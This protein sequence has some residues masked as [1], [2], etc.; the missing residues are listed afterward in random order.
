M[1]V[2]E[3]DV[4]SLVV[5]LAVVVLINDDACS[6]VNG[7]TYLI[8]YLI[9]STVFTSTTL[10]PIPTVAFCCPLANDPPLTAILICFAATESRINAGEEDWK[11]PFRST[12]WEVP[13]TEMF[14]AT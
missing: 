8:T 4:V 9:E 2:V 5:P 3:F 1:V 12:A 14:A 13:L 6:A 7:V 10:L 11:V